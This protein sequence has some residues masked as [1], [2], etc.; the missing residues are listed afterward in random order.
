MPSKRKKKNHLKKQESKVLDP[1]NIIKNVAVTNEK[2]N[3]T[4][5]EYITI[6]LKE[7]SELWEEVKKTVNAN[8]EFIK[9]PDKD[10]IDLF[11]KKYHMFQNEFPIV[12]RYMICMGQYKESAFLKYL[13]KVK[14]FKTK[15]PDKREKGYMEEIW[16][17]RQ[18]H[19]SKS[20]ARNTVLSRK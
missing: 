1:T 10:K 17:D 20:G 6:A 4:K 11:M 15:D 19:H 2:M 14:N 3:Q 9:L 7:A 5:E 16:I 8:P 12:C 13:K 18:A